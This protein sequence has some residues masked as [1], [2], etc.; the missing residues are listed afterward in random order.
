MQTFLPYPD[1]IWVARI[2]DN[3]R[4]GSQRKEA[5]QIL[6]TLAIGGRWE[7]HPAVRMWRGY[8]E[9]LGYYMNIMMLEWEKRGNNNDK[10]L[11]YIPRATKLIMP[12]WMGDHRLHESHRANL[13]RKKPEYYGK[14]WPK[15]DKEAPYWWPCGLI[16]E[17]KQK[18]MEEYWNGGSE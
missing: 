2:L 10:L 13:A 14:L 9:M 1:F 4:L 5:Q 18:A 11:Y 6:R 15:A 17:K 12:P 8:E 7:N 3:K 16:N